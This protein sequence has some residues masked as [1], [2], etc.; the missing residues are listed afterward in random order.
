MNAIIFLFLAATA[1][2]ICA[3]EQIAYQ[4]PNYIPKFPDE[5]N[6][7][8]LGLNS[9]REMLN[10]LEIE[11]PKPWDDAST[12]ANVATR[13]KEWFE[14]AKEKSPEQARFLLKNRWI[15]KD[16]ENAEQQ[17]ILRVHVQLEIESW[18]ER[19]N[20]CP[21][22]SE[23]LTKLARALLDRVNRNYDSPHWSRNDRATR[24]IR[25]LLQ[26][27]PRSYPVK[28][29]ASFSVGETSQGWYNR[30][31]LKGISYKYE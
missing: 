19:Q 17:R 7:L 1:L 14:H 16:K 8:N 2:P 30:Y 24:E 9:L 11:E 21:E 10:I 12:I 15:I 5:P 31:P 23:W 13:L 25:T 3:M 6:G 27:T 22:P 26:N 18:P 28:M 4:D 20:D 29:S